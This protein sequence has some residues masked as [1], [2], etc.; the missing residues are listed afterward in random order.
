MGKDDVQ[1]IDLI[2]EPLTQ[3]AFAEFGTVIDPQMDKSFLINEGT[4]RRFDDLADVDV[5]I[6]GGT[7][8]ISIF[9]A[10]R[11]AFPVQI[12]MMEKHPLGSQA[13]LPMQPHPWIVV[14]ATG[15]VPSA[16]TCRAFLANGNQG[17]QY[18][19]GTWHHPLLIRVPTQDFWIVD[20]KGG[21]ENL[22]EIMFDG[23]H[24]QVITTPIDLQESN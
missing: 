23:E 1:M 20:R 13:F 7:P 6:G 15:D 24:A 8:I 11:R 17:V 3:Q 5:S 22:E 16:A 19:T 18:A 12:K 9:S 4:T 10:Q 21:G 14:V 2:P